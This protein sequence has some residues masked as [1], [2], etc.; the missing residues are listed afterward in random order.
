MKIIQNVI[1]FLMNHKVPTIIIVDQN[2][3]HIIDLRLIMNVNSIVLIEP[4]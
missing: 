1:G 2:R 4:R 3:Y